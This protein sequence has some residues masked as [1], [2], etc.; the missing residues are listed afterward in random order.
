M[1]FEAVQGDIINFHADA[2]VNSSG[3]EVNMRRAIGGA[4][5][6]SANGPIAEEASAKGPVRLGKT[7]VTNAYDLNADHVIHAAIIPDYGD[8]RA[9]AQ[10]IRDGVQNSLATA[11][12]LECESIIL[13]TLGCGVVGFDTKEG[14]RIIANEIWDFDAKNMEKVLFNGYTEYAFNL[15]ES[16]HDRLMKS[17]QF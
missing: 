2:I 12:S 10:S 9:T 8:G 17:R 4:L 7:V 15:I 11:D 13:P 5:R 1:K 16:E 14:V 6:R 3:T